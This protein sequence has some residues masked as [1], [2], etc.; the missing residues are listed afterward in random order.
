[1]KLGV[2]LA[3]LGQVPD[4]CVTLGEVIVRFPGVPA[5]VEAQANMARLGCQ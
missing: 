1:M 5:A 2:A 4:A 3:A